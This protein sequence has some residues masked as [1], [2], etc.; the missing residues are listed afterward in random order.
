M[1]AV[2]F[3]SHDQ[4]VW[5]RYTGFDIS[6]LPWNVA[7]IEEDKSFLL[8][9]ISAV[10]ESLGATIYGALKIALSR[11]RVLIQSFVAEHANVDQEIIW[12]YNDDHPPKEFK[13]CPNDQVYL[14]ENGCVVCGGKRKNPQ[15]E[16]DPRYLSTEKN[17]GDVKRVK[18]GFVAGTLVHTE[19][20]VVP[21][22]KI[23][24]GDMVLSTYRANDPLQYKPVLNVAVHRDSE[25]WLLEHH[26]RGLPFSNLVLTGNQEFSS[27]HK[28]HTVDQLAGKYIDGVYVKRNSSWQ[29]VHRARRILKTN[30]L[31]IGWT[32]ADSCRYGTTVDLRDSQVKVSKTYEEDSVD[33]SAYEINEYLSHQVY[34]IDL[35]ESWYFF[36]GEPGVLTKTLRL[37]DRVIQDWT[38]AA[39]G[40][41]LRAQYYLGWEYSY[42][43]LQ[44][45]ERAMYW[46]RKAAE[47]TLAS[48]I[49]SDD[50]YENGI[51][52]Q[53]HLANMYEQGFGVPKDYKLAVFW[54]AAAAARGSPVAKYFLG[55][56]HK[57]GL[58]IDQDVEQARSL[59][60]E[61][62]ELGFQNA[63]SE[64]Q[65]MNW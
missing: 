14:H 61:S 11:L 59:I 19:N 42:S 31:S 28:W 60:K 48:P 21:I 65:K 6:T 34:N 45:H 53:L 56:M 22:E 32:H 47:F 50:M 58:G 7:N 43:S 41:N 57:D 10:L 49:D 20:G 4:D 24:V 9:V 54:Y 37:S 23:Q 30:S 38:L 46:H 36:V 3:A 16:P 5:G 8:A 52:S 35:G 51:A 33:I 44:N 55:L 26:N 13:K 17:L 27:F 2:W 40:G 1:F 62:A 64:V 63:I 15:R 29:T 25:V 12:A 39:E 18:S